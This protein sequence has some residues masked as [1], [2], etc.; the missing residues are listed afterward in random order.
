MMEWYLTA[1]IGRRMAGCL[2][3]S[4]SGRQRAFLKWN[5]LDILESGLFGLLKGLGLSLGFSIWALKI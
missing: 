2:R 5:L 3:R 4:N 1:E